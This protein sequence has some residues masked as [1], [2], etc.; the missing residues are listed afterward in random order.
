MKLLALL[1]VG[2]LAAGTLGAIPA[3]AQRYGGDG[4]RGDRYHDGYGDHRGFRDDGYR[5]FDRRGGYGY[6]GGYRPRGGYG[7]HGGYRGRGYYGR[8]RIVCRIRPGYYGPVRRCFRA[9]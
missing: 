2:A 5:G 9:Y 7:F 6:G 8:P 1:G 4:Y 3:D